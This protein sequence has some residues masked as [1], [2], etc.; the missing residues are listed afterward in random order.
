[1]IAIAGSVRL[2]SAPTATPRAN[3]NSAQP[4]WT[5]GAASNTLRSNTLMVSTPIFGTLSSMTPDTTPASAARQ[6]VTAPSRATW[7]ASHREADTSCPHAKRCVRSSYSRA[8]SGAPQNMPA[9]SANSS[10]M[11]ENCSSTR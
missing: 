3:A 2:V 8:T 7:P 11:D 4:T 1:M 6:A 10:P 5:W 9:A